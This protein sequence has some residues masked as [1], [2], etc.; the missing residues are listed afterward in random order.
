M[1]SPFNEEYV[2]PAVGNAMDSLPLTISLFRLQKAEL[3]GPTHN[4]CSTQEYKG[5]AISIQFGKNF[6]AL[7]L[8]QDSL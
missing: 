4:V 2:A 8:L 3:Q 5:L 1:R 7:S 6:A